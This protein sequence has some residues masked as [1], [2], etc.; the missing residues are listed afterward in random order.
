MHRWKS[1]ASL[2]AALL[3]GMTGTE[4]TAAEDDEGAIKY[5]Q[6]VMSSVGGHTGAIYQIVKNDNPN[7]SHLQAHARALHDLTG[8]IASAFQPMTSGGK[9]RAKAKIWTDVSGFESAVNDARTAAGALESAASSGND[10]EISQKLDILL[11]S[12][13]GCHREYREKKE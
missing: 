12:C 2:V 1:C 6:S 3:I 5:R 8:M 7:K 13:K 11:D 10:A 9:T 4:V